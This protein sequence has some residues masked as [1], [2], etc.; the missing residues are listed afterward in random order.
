MR[1]FPLGLGLVPARMSGE[2][3]GTRLVLRC[4]RSPRCLRVMNKIGHLILHGE[5][6]S[7]VARGEEAKEGQA[8][9]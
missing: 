8:N 4:G 7:D 9:A 3:K 1:G 6:S 5:V 2:W